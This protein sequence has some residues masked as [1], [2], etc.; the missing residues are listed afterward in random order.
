MKPKLKE[1][2]FFENAKNFTVVSDIRGEED[3]FVIKIFEDN[4][5]YYL[6][7]ITDKSIKVSNTPHIYSSY[8]E[9]K[10]D[11][12]KAEKYYENISI[13]PYSDIFYIG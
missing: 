8:Q 1:S 2:N 11:M 7:R 9:A 5:Y 4:T 13:A 12:E 6:E 10:D 3:E